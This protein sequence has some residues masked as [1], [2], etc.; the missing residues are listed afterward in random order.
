M[1]WQLALQLGLWRNQ[2]TINNLLTGQRVLLVMPRFF[3]YEIEIKEGLEKEGAIVDWLPDRPFDSPALKALAKL[4]P[5]WFLPFT[6][7]YYQYLLKGFNAQRYNKIFVINGQTLSYKFLSELRSRYPAAEVILYMW[8][9]IK[10]RPSTLKNISLF[11]KVFSFDYEGSKGYGL[12]HRPLF[13]TPG[14]K[15]STN[16]DFTYQLSFIGTAHTDRYDVISRVK[17]NLSTDIKTFWYLYLQAPWVF[18]FY[19][20]TKSNFHGAKKSD[21]SFKSL[22]QAIV[23]SIFLES[24]AILDVEHPQQTGLTM[25]SLESLG[26]HKKLITT[27][28][29]IKNYD[30]YN[31]ANICIINRKNPK[32]PN[33]FF[34]EKFIPPP[35]RVYERYSLCGWLNEIFT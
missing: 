14:F 9:S 8:D 30:F 20:I 7:A 1:F 28:Q 27:N 5:N 24:F 13:F 11:D 3:G 18:N 6:D 2:L 25:R 33:N 15:P 10:N 12:V 19:K 32:I 16:N 17:N 21:F 34:D 29:H 35:A 26:A 23:Q 31:P 22:D 4:K